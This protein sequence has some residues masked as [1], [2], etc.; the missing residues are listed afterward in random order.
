MTPYADINDP[1]GGEHAVRVQ[2]P[3]VL[4]ATG[5]RTGDVFEGRAAA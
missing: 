3:Y 5:T 1:V 2:L 4:R